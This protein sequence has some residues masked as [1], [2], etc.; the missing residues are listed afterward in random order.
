MVYD[1]V[2]KKLGDIDELERHDIIVAGIEKEK[3]IPS[4][5]MS[6]EIDEGDTIIV[7]GAEEVIEEIKKE[8][9]L[10]SK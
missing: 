2:S 7:M 6:V 1:L 10:K 8:L 4:P 9:G 3:M 5:D